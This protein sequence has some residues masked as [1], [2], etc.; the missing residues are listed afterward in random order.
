MHYDKLKV[1]LSR[2]LDMNEK[3][4][5]FIDDEDYLLRALRRALHPYGFKVLTAGTV[6]EAFTILQKQDIPVVVC[7]EMM[8]ILDGTTLLSRIKKEYPNTIRI[9]MSGQSDFEILQRAINVGEIYKFIPKPCDTEQL[10]NEL[11]DALSIY[12]EN[13]KKD[14]N[15][16]LFNNSPESIITTDMNDIIESANIPF[17]LASAY[18]KDEIEGKNIWETILSEIDRESKKEIKDEIS[19]NKAWDGDILATMKNGRKLNIFLSISEIQYKKSK[20]GFR[21]YTFINTSSLSR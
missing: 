18:S 12:R 15:S 9:L 5:L 10:V 13:E 6:D 8:P 7:D 4:V 2:F 3:T 16:L 11:D 20:R 21:S 17:Y 1:T 14:Q 19:Q